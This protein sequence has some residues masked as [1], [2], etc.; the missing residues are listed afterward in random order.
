M[1][2]FVAYPQNLSVAPIWGAPRCL[3]DCHACQWLTVP[4][5]CTPELLR[6]LGNFPSSE[7]AKPHLTKHSVHT[8]G[9]PM[10]NARL[11][12]CTLN[13]TAQPEQPLSVLLGLLPS[14]WWSHDVF[15][16]SLSFTPTCCGSCCDLILQQISED[17]VT[18]C[19]TCW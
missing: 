5:I 17:A 12:H 9:K 2:R 14:M 1:E 8:H 11:R 6:C 18:L 16:V 15:C 13:P 19:P 3:R 7:M 10:Q 4:R